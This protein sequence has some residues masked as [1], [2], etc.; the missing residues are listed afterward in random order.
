METFSISRAIVWTYCLQALSFVPWTVIFCFIRFVRLYHLNTKEEYQCLQ[1]KLTNQCSIITDGEHAKGY[2]YACGP[3]FVA[4]LGPIKEVWLLCSPETFE[5]LMKNTAN[6]IRITRE[7]YSKS[8]ECSDEEDDDDEYE[9]FE[10]ELET[11][12]IYDR[13]GDYSCPYYKR[14]RIDILRLVPRPFQK[15]MMEAILQH[16]TKHLRTVVF[17]SGPPNTGKSILGLLLATLYK[18]SYCT[19]FKPWQPGDVLGEL[20]NEVEPK[21]ENPFILV[22]DEIDIALVKIHAG[23]LH[24]KIPISVGDKQGWNNFLD[25]IHWGMFPYMIV[26]LISNKPIDFINKLDPSYLREGR[27]DIKF[28]TCKK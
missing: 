21:K 10:Q 23:I 14:R 22:L 24:K 15:Q 12:K 6:Q 8:N 3:W 9:E 19:S 2:G 20:Y 13:L 18:S 1:K 27:V 25:Q 16:Y 28:E 7:E 4:Y 26:L 17:L 11:I 5:K